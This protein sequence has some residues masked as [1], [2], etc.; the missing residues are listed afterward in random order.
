MIFQ[1]LIENITSAILDN[2]RR[3]REGEL[4]QV[5][6]LKKIIDMY[7]FLSAERLTNESLSC[8]KYL[9]DKIIEQT[10]YFYQ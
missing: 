1:P 9:E 3:E 8:K 6:L 4:I 10:R 2:I 7:L 5:D